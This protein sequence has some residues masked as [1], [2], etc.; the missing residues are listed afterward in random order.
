MKLDEFHV[1]TKVLLDRMVVEWRLE[2][3][4][5]EFS[6]L[7]WFAEMVAYLGTHFTSTPE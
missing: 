2:R 6:E 5:E 7:R 3:E 1:K 4:N